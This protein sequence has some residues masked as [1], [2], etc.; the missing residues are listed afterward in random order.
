MTLCYLTYETNEQRDRL[1]AHVGSAGG[2]T[3]A[4]ATRERGEH[5]GIGRAA[6]RPGRIAAP[7]GDRPGSM[8]RRG[9]D[10]ARSWP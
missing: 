5:A 9:A 6:R 4:W 2:R 7:A 10:L 3:R 8:A 1:T